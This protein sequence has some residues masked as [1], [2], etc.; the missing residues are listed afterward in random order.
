MH[1]FADGHAATASRS[2][3][4]RSDLEFVAQ[5]LGDPVDLPVSNFI[6]SL[7]HLKAAKKR[8]RVASG[9]ASVA[10]PADDAKALLT[11]YN[12]PTCKTN[13]KRHF[14]EA[15]SCSVPAREGDWDVHLSGV[16]HQR[17]LVSLLHTGQLGNTVVSLFE[18]EPGTTG[19]AS[20]LAY[21][22]CATS[23]R[24]FVSMACFA[25]PRAIST[26]DWG[27]QSTADYSHLDKIR[28]QSTKTLFLKVQFIPSTFLLCVTQLHAAQE[29][30]DV[31]KVAS[32]KFA[33]VS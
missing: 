12:T 32:A 17:Q 33:H 20:V 26:S 6:P 9:D 3:G 2:A 5:L 21:F 7:R 1:M 16:K 19:D 15:C 10:G 25:V 14:C 31:S 30:K 8:R 4:P 28:L 27:K 13:S 29:P 11:R 18:A 24:H 23:Q 22:H